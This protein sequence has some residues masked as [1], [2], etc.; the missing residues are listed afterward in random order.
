[1]GEQHDRW[2]LI[3]NPKSGKKKFRQQIK[4]LFENL[5]KN[6]VAYEYQFTRF[7]GHAQYIAARFVR[8][9][10]KNFLVVGG[11]GTIS[12]VVNGIFSTNPLH[13]SAMK[14]AIVPRGT[15]NDWARFWGLTR[16]YRHSIEVFLKQKTRLIDVGKVN[17]KL[18]DENL[19]HYFINS[20][21]FGL[22]AAVV[23][24]TNHLR[25]FFGSHSFLYFFAL[26]RAVFTY[27]ASKTELKFNGKISNKNLFTMNIANG[28]YSGGGMKQNPDALPYDG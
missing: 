15:G 1:M 6:G 13:T 11:D 16:D 28:C 25:R 21:G 5:E 18:E 22:D 4:Y 19:T 24:I 20:V 27:R 26:L 17:Y 12:E 3:I 9:N 7:A 2:A 23:R 10:F 8:Q 14:L